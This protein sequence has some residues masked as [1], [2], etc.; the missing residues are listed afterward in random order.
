M[1]NKFISFINGEDKLVLVSIEDINDAQLFK[2]KKL[3]TIGL[4]LGNSLHEREDFET[5]IDAERKFNRIM[6]L[7]NGRNIGTKN[8]ADE[9]LIKMFVVPEKCRQIVLSK[10][11]NKKDEFYEK[12]FI[13]FVFDRSTLPFVNDDLASEMFESEEE[14]RTVFSGLKKQLCFNGFDVIENTEG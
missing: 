14:A 13:K 7:T 6:A 3:F 1:E 5:L 2:N 4:N 11:D 9:V 10:N 12:W 8:A